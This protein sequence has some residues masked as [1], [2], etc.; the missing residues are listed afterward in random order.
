MNTVE[1]TIDVAVPVHTAYNQWTQFESFPRFMALV[2]D[3]E[4]LRPNLLR[5]V[6][7]RGP[8]R[9]E[10]DVEIVEQVPD[11]H[12]AWRSLDRRF[13]HQGK[14]LFRAAAPERTTVVARLDVSPAG[15]GLL[16][17]LPGLAPRVVHA[18][19]VHFKEFIESVGQEG[20]SWR[21]T[22]RN[23]HVYPVGPEPARSRVPRWPVG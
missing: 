3:V 22:I 19:L 11:S 21:G 13:M 15:M 12:V 18:E 7:G 6:V 20:G 5:W 2:K 16:A 1:E 23:G 10:F 9:H 4:Q 14:V 17:H 8:L